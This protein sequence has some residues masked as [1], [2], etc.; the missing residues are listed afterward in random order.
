MENLTTL[1][2]IWGAI[3]L[4]FLILVVY[5]RTLTSQ[6]KDWIPLH[7]IDKEGS[8]IQAQTQIESKTRK[9]TIPIRALGT[10]SLVMLLVIVGIYVYH[11]LTTQP[12]IQ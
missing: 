12:V 3:T 4:A 6:E 11:M 2:S 8:A 10:V 5:R 7:D 1:A 9:L